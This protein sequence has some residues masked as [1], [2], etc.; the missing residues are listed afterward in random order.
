MHIKNFSLYK[1]LIIDFKVWQ[2][3]CNVARVTAVWYFVADIN[4]NATCAINVIKQIYAPRG[5]T[6]SVS[7]AL[8]FIDR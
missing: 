1:Y 8:A 5:S 6:T 4:E 2:Q 3:S 7:A